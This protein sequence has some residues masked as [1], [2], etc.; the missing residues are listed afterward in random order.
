V[1]GHRVHLTHPDDVLRD[2]DADLWDHRN[3]SLRQYLVD[4]VLG[5]TGLGDPN[6]SGL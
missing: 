5:P 4:N 1:L 6:I 3:A 2:C